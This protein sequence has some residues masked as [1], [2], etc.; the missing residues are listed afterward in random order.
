[1]PYSEQIFV[2][3]LSRVVG[4]WHGLHDRGLWGYVK[5]LIYINKPETTDVLEGSIWRVIVDIRR[6]LVW[7]AVESW[8]SRMELIRASRVGHLPKIVF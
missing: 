2:S 4:M 7:K 1:M 8:L 3:W 5:S 6:Q